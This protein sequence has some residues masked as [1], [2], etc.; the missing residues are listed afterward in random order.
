MSEVSIVELKPQLVLGLK[1]TGYYKEIAEMI[2]KL[3]MYADSVGAK[4]IGAPIFVCHETAEQAMEAQKN[5]NAK[6]E[7]CIP[8]S[9]RID[10]KEGMHC[11]ELGGGTF[12]KTVHKGPY[13]ECGP[14]YEKMFKWIASQGKKVVG[15]T[16]EYYVNDPREVK[17]E[18]ILT[19]IYAPIE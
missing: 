10:E 2:P 16:R 6:L 19:E 9:K 14:C 3:C 12:A 1:R 18:E 5:G 15:P 7:V 17:P 13:E 8:V 4:I 11:Y